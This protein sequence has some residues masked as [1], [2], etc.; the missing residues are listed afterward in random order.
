MSRRLSAEEP[1]CTPDRHLGEFTNGRCSQCGER[2]PARDFHAGFDRGGW[3]GGLL[4]IL[5]A[6][7]AVAFFLI[8]FVIS[9]LDK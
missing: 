6:V 9:S 7:L 5:I 1:G 2:D 4:V 8:L 3:A